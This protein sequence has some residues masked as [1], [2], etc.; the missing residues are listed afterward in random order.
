MKANDIVIPVL[1]ALHQLQLPFMLVGSFSSNMYGEERTT[2][3]ADFVIQLTRPLGEL[4]A[5]LG[6]RFRLDSQLSFETVT[7][8]SRYVAEFEEGPFKIEFFLLRDD[9]YDQE[10]F[11]RR[12]AKPFRDRTVFVPTAEDVVV[13]KLR[14][15]RPKDIIDARLVIAVQIGK[16]DLAYIRKWCAEFGKRDLLE[17]LLIEA[18]SIS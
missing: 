14:W 2:Q 1:D 10:R 9:P 7:M 11:R 17:R 16:L 18:A 5:A 13:Q 3:D 12:V 4:A 8:T 15:S 6:P